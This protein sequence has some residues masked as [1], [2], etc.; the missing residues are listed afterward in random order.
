MLGLRLVRK[1]LA[2]AHGHAG[3][4]SMCSIEQMYVV[5]ITLTAIRVWQKIPSMRSVC[6]ADMGDGAVSPVLEV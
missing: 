6:G 5:I 3:R 2:V 4:T 1:V